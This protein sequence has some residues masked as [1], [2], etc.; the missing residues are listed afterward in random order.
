MILY[1]NLENTQIN[2]ETKIAKPVLFLTSSELE[3]DL[4]STAE[5]KEINSFFIQN[6]LNKKQQNLVLTLFKEANINRFLITL[7]RG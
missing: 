1:T 7:K 3:S 4:H 2:G 6:N 5:E